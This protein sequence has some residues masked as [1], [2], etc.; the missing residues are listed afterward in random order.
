MN[1]LRD[2]DPAAKDPGKERLVVGRGQTVAAEGD[3]FVRDDPCPRQTG[4]KIVAGGQASLTGTS[5]APQEHRPAGRERAAAAASVR[6]AAAAGFQRGR[7]SGEIT[8][9][10][11][12]GPG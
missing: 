2:G 10:T 1:E 6:K 12:G 5:P 8:G 7:A 4:A 9:R 3:E 11:A